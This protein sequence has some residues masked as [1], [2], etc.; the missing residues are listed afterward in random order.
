MGICSNYLNL[1]NNKINN[2]GKRLNRNFAEI[3]G[4][5]NLA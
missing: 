2:N 5:K 1:L 3:Q 4:L